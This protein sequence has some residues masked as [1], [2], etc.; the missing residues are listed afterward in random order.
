MS[1]DLDD[2]KVRNYCHI[3]MHFLDALEKIEEMI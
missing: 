1:V 3:S 2:A